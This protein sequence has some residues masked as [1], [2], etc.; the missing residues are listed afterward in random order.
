MFV[1]GWLVVW[2]F[3]NWRLIIGYRSVG[4]WKLALII[5]ILRRNIEE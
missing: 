4:H 2:L 3:E 5:L 1:F